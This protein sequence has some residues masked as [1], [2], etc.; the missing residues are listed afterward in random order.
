[1]ANISLNPNDAVA[2]GLLDDVTAKWSNCRFQ[3]YDYDGKAPKVP[4][5]AFDLVDPESGEEIGSQYYKAGNA[6]NVQPTS[7]GKGIEPI[8]G[9]T[10]S[11]NNK[12]RFFQLAVSLKNAGMDDEKFSK[13]TD[14]CS[15]LNGLIAHMA[16]E[17]ALSKPLVEK[18]RQ[19][20]TVFESTVLVVN[21]VK[22]WPWEKTSGAATAA[23][24]KGK[25]KGAAAKPAAA[26]AAG[27]EDLEDK[28]VAFVLSVVSELGA[29]LKKDIPGET[30][31]RLASDPQKN[32]VLRVIFDDAWL[33]AEGR[34]WNYADGVITLA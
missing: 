18:K 7:D 25:G 26:P 5:F 29:L 3:M 23:A 17:P 22:K 28:S 20:G 30:L 9:K 19:D 16:Q 21:S 24:G 32:A 2:G 10:G 13:F 15:I 31:G 27:G 33:G 1:M 14:D 11:I 4:A 6:D 34:P 8:P 12:S